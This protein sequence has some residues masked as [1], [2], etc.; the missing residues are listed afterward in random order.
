MHFFGELAPDG[1]MS[2]THQLTRALPADQ[3]G[4]PAPG[5]EEGQ[6]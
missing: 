1:R 5:K 6:G 3:D 4:Q 2:R